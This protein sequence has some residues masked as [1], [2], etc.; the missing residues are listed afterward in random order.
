LT[1]RSAAFIVKEDGMTSVR[2]L[3]I[4][5]AV[6]VGMAA[7]LH[8]PAGPAS[9]QQLNTLNVT[10][11]DYTFEFKGT[12]L[13][14]DQPVVITLKNLDKVTHGF[15]S[16]LLGQ[17]EVEIESKGATTYGKGIRGLHINPGET[18]TIRFTPMKPGRY[19]FQCDIHP[20]MKKGEVLLLSIGEV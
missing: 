3:L 19:Q 18:V 13:K 9:A 10:I 12:V 8:L 16:P 20:N 4:V 14:P 11:R 7:A 2:R 15:M 1:P 6:G 5:L 17:Q